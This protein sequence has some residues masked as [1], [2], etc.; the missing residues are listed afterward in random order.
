MS[1][2]RYGRRT[3]EDQRVRLTSQR[4]AAVEEDA[5]SRFRFRLQSVRV[6][7]YGEQA[8]HD[9]VAVECLGPEAFGPQGS[10]HIRIFLLQQFTVEIPFHMFAY[11]LHVENVVDSTKCTGDFAVKPTFS[12]GNSEV[13]LKS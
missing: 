4:F 12:I 11:K 5:P 3:N 1:R 8:V 7:G 6:S 2:R 9:I 13:V 10:E